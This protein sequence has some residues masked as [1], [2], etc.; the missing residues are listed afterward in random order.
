[1]GEGVEGDRY[2]GISISR[3]REGLEAKRAA[4]MGVMSELPEIPNNL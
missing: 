1:M 3:G 4:M 2:D